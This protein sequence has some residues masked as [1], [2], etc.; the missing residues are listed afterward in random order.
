MLYLVCV[1]QAVAD[2]K[3]SETVANKLG[4]MAF[5]CFV[6]GLWACGH[7]SIPSLNSVYSVLEFFF[8]FFDNI[9]KTVEWNENENELYNDSKWVIN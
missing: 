9:V 4:L 7:L 3:E 1:V 2:E 6:C 8:F 5:H